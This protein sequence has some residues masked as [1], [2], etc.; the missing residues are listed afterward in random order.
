MKKRKKSRSTALTLAS[1]RRLPAKILMVRPL[2]PLV[3]TKKGRYA[4]RITSRRLPPILFTAAQDKRTYHP[5]PR[6]TS[7]LSGIPSGALTV[8]RKLHQLVF[9]K[10]KI[11]TLCV[12]RQQR[13]EVMHA[14]G[15]AGSRGLGRRKRRRT[16]EESHIKC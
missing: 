3:T 7:T 10:P 8:G 9:D 13:K 14:I 1:R 16:N 15:K 4:H 12:R 6:P 11:I 2:S 5:H